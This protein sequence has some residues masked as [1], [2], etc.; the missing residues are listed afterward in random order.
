MM[1]FLTDSIKV[2]VLLCAITIDL[3]TYILDLRSIK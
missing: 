3:L 1:M 2:Q